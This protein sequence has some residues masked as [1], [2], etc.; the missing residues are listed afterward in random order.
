MAIAEQPDSTSF[1]VP[2]GGDYWEADPGVPL[3]GFADLHA[4]S[5]NC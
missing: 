5:R 3:W 4:L 1:R 2:L